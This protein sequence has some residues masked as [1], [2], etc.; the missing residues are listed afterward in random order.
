MPK[1][2]VILPTY[3]ERENI[4]DLI[5]SIFSNMDATTEVIVVDDNSPDKTWEVIEKIEKANNNVRLLRR[6]NKRGLTSA[7]SDGI[8]LSEG[9]IVVWMDCDFSMPPEII[10]KLIYELNDSDIALG[11]RYV[12]GGKD[13]RDSSIRILASRAVNL[14]ANFVLDSSIKDYSSGF[15]AVKREVFNEIKLMPEGYAEYCVD[16]L[17]RAKKRGFKIKEVPY[18]VIDRRVGETKTSPNVLT[19]LRHGIVY[20]LTVLKL[21]VVVK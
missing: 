1:I 2:S 13:V 17:Y 7:I 15:F 18:I 12:K 10:P 3:N 11:S 8:S 6:M 21:R 16:F 5:N 20:I 4:E 14:F 19:F 9:D